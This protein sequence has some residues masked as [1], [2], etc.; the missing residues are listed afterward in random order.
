MAIYAGIG[1]SNYFEIKDGLFDN[2][3]KLCGYYE[4]DVL[5]EGDKVMLFPSV[6][7]ETGD[8]STYIDLERIEREDGVSF[9][10]SKI[11][12][13]FRNTLEIDLMQDVVV[14]GDGSLVSDSIYLPDFLD[15]I[16]K[17]LKPGEVFIWK[18]VGNEKLR[19][20]SGY[21]FSVDH[22]NNQKT[23]NLDDIFLNFLNTNIFPSF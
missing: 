18:H 19:Y 10:N 6:I 8:I 7:N 22:L 3:K 23:I 13:L 11:A 17:F 21:S 16:Y 14:D 12:S 5:R 20:I 9:K 1:R 4:L 15:I 2:F